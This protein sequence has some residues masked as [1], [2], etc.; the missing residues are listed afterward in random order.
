MGCNSFGKFPRAKNL[1]CDP[2]MRV[3][4]YEQA[5]VLERLCA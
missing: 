2:Q 1:R 4:F 3:G 5:D